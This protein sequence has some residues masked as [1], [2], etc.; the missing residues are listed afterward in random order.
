M[1][2][3]MMTLHLVGVVLW[4]GSLLQVS[5]M[6]KGHGQA[7]EA[8][9]ETLSSIERRT[10]LLVGIPGMLATLG[11]GVWLLTQH[12]KYFMKQGWFHTKLTLVLVVIALEVTLF[13]LVGRYR[14]APG[15]KGLPLLLHIVAGLALIAIVACMKV[16]RFAA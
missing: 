3:W 16:W 7:A 12:P 15:G 6:L 5:R 9:R 10:Q 4:F 8:A 14:K 11:A 13:V 2:G 1:H